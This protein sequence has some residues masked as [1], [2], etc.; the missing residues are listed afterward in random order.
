MVSLY[1]VP[2]FIDAL[3]QAINQSLNSDIMV[4]V[5]NNIRLGDSINSN[6][7][8]WQGGC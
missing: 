5:A 8:A 3:E 1:E 2:L 6:G 4:E 7:D